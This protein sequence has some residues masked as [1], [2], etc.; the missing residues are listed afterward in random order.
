MLEQQYV[1]ARVPKLEQLLSC[2]SQDIREVVY[3]KA[4]TK[5]D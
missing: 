3:R 1:R 2:P 4:T 5:D